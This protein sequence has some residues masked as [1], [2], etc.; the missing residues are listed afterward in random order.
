M[1]QLQQ[2]QQRLLLPRLSLLQLQRHLLRGAPLQ[3]ARR[4]RW[5]RRSERWESA[6]PTRMPPASASKLHCMQA[7]PGER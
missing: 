2:R 7:R 4:A 3:Q 5:R 6:P 1:W